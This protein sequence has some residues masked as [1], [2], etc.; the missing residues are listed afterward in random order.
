MRSFARE[1]RDR[2]LRAGV[3]PLRGRA[4]LVPG[5]GGDAGETEE[6][7]SVARH[8]GQLERVEGRACGGAALAHA[9]PDRQGRGRAARAR[10]RRARGRRGRCSRGRARG[11]ARRGARRRR[12]V[13]AAAAA[14]E[15]EHPEDEQKPG[16]RFRI[17]RQP[18]ESSM[19]C[20][21]RKE[22]RF[23]DD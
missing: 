15:G 20:R 13:V 16:H 3:V 21:S 22:R 12:G 1:Q 14:G 5:E 23:D 18:G 7:A 10:G 2:V 8:V 17:G 6:V 4:E 11:G 19:L 9:D